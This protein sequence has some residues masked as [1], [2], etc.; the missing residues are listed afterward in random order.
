MEKRPLARGKLA[1]YLVILIAASTASVIF[2][3]RGL[4][5]LAFAGIFILPAALLLFDRPRWILYIL[6]GL[7]FSCVYVFFDF[8]LVRLTS[9]FM[10][11]AWA[12]M[13]VSE[14]RVIVHDPVMAVLTTAFLLCAFQSMIFARDIA[15]SLFR[16][17]GF[18]KNLVYIFLIMQFCRTRGDLLRIFIAISAASMISN[19]MPFFVPPPDNQSSLSLIWN[20]GIYRYE[21]YLREANM[22]AFS[23]IFLLPILLFLFARLKRPRFVRFLI[24]AATAGT[25]FVLVLSF[26]RGGF[27]ALAFMLL[28]LLFVERRNKAVVITGLAMVAVAAVMAPAAYWSRIGSLAEIGNRMTEDT[29]ILSRLYTMKIAVMLGLRNPLF[30]IG[31]ENF[32]FHVARFI[33]LPNVVH[34]SFL[35]VFSDLGFPGLIVFV[36]MLVYNLRVTLSLMRSREDHEKALLGRILLVQQV[37]VIVNT[38]FLPVAYY[39]FTWF[40]MAIPTAVKYAYDNSENGSGGEVPKR[41]GSA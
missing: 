35:Q 30:G 25:V 2:L 6:L 14:R 26:S 32:L 27:V 24:A 28:A 4:I 5:R 1:F 20:E 8:P 13:A 19:F 15:S 7:I 21:G 29:A 37:A 34:N 23:I 17:D 9:I 36:W 18:I 40:T 31:I 12:Y 39:I 16:L 22:F 3:P 33:P 41:H 11:A 10:A 38:L